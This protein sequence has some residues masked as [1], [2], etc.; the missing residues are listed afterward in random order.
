MVNDTNSPGVSY[1]D[2]VTFNVSTSASYP[3]VELDCS[4]GGTLVYA[5]TAGFYP[6]YGWS[7]DYTLSGGMWTGGAAD[8]TATLYY[9]TK[10]GTNSTL[11]TLSFPAGA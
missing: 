5:H 3:S 10:N 9:T 4:Q 8:C 7:R 2:T 11:A 1:G 6:S